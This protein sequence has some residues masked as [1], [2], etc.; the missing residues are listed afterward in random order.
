MVVD[1]VSIIRRLVQ[2]ALA[3]D[4]EIS[5]VGTAANGRDALEKIPVVRPDLLVLDYEMPEMDGLETLVEVRKHHP[6]IRVVIFSSYTRHGA[7]V[8]LDALWF[9]ADDYVTKA[10]ADNLAAATDLVRTQLVPKIKALCSRGSAGAIAPAAL[11][12]AA[13]SPPSAPPASAGAPAARG[14]RQRSPS[15]ATVVAIGASTGGPKALAQLVEKIPPDFP[16]PILIVQHMPPLFTKYLAERLATR[17]PWRCAEGIDGAL[18]EPGTVWVAPGDLHMT[19]ERTGAETRIRLSNEPPV[20]SCRPAV[21]PLFRSIAEAY[22]AGALAVVLTG[23]G[24]D[25]VQGSR[26]VREAGGQVLAQDEASSVVWGMPGIVVREGIAD[27]VGTPEEIAVEIAQRVLAS[28]RRRT[29]V[30]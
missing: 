17:S 2:D 16:A 28:T 23:M 15:R 8:T 18:L 14:A 20:H 26:R 6:G 25:G 29:P 12:A 27:F 22:G 10:R 1:D 24:H 11:A 9:G 30:G 3:T 21:D 7:K 19:V 4:P 13:A 5:V